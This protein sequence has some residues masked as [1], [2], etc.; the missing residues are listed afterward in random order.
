MKTTP[1]EQKCYRDF[2]SWGGG[3]GRG[4]GCQIRCMVDY[5]KERE[6]FMPEIV[7]MARQLCHDCTF[8]IIKTY[9]FIIRAV[10]RTELRF[11]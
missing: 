11:R 5:E 10:R 6:T 8:L 9:S 7:V 1:K 3:G 2:D 4:G